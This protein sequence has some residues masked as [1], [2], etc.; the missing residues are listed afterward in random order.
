MFYLMI[1][2][3]VLKSGPTKHRKQSE[4]WLLV[5]KAGLTVTITIYLVVCT[6]PKT[7]QCGTRRWANA[8]LVAF[9]L[10]DDAFLVRYLPVLS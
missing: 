3:L 1:A 9:S 10:M 2:R 5:L 6:T 4:K 7:L 8:L